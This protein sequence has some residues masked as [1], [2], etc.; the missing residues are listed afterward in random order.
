MSETADKSIRVRNVVIGTVVVAVIVAT[1]LLWRQSREEPERG[2][3]PSPAADPGAATPV[4]P[5]DGAGRGPGET[6]APVDAERVWT[7]LTGEP[8]RWPSDFST[9]A[10]CEGVRND[11]AR[12]CAALDVR[13]PALREHGGACTLIEQLGAELAAAPPDLSSELRSY[14]ALLRNVFHL[15]RIA[16]RERMRVIRR[17]LAEQDLAEPAALAL[18]RWAIS[19]ERCSRSDL[20]P[21]SSE[22]LYAYAGF[23][24][25]TLGG[26]AYLRRRSP[27]VEAL[28]C[29]Y[30]LQ[31]LDG[32]IRGGHNPHGLDP[33]PEIPRCRD[34]VAL[35][36]FVFADRYGAELEEM[37]RR[38]KTR[39]AGEP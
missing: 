13:A 30:G 2:S 7:E 35:Q 8:P 18:Y 12:I 21:V 37:S 26:Q 17:A 32:A 25:N 39:E 33:R 29:F 15:F 38:W 19:Q 31:V 22:A 28:A 34:L 24:F 14:D 9:P 36:D 3:T 27:R 16:G 11:L 23:L 1:V 6:A 20:H 10:S 4:A 5:E